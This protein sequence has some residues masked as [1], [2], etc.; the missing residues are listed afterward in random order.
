MAL[1]DAVET[2]R[3]L[4]HYQYARLIAEAAG[5]DDDG[6]MW[7]KFWK[8]RNGN[9]E[10]SSLTKE[11]KYQLQEGFG[12]CIYCGEEGETT[13]DHLVPISEGGPDTISNQV[14]A[15]QSCNSQKNDKDVIQWYGERDEP[16]PRIV[17]GK[18][19]K[20][21]FEQWDVQDR[22]DE[23]LPAEVEKEWDGL[24]VT[25][26]VSKRIRKRYRD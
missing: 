4:I 23:P 14:P 20:L 6:F 7:G 25:R 10:M 24:E 11:D 9:I 12:E 18:Y 26:N 8:L 5:I 21:M 17:W 3:D 1:P 2:Y 15:C 22:L 16:V 13:F 19:L